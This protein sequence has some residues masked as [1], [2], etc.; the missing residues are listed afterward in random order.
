ATGQFEHQP[1]G[2]AGG[3]TAHRGGAADHDAALAGSGDVDRGVAQARGD[4]E[5]ERGQ[6]LDDRAREGG[7]LAHGAD[8][9]EALQRRDDLVLPA[10]VRV[11]DLDI[12]V[13]RNLRPVGRLEGD[14]LIVVEDRAAGAGHGEYPGWPAE[15]SDREGRRT[16]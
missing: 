10:K 15:A 7:A 5:L 14:I 8:D 3:R 1:N 16:L 13:T 12:E 4:K 6:F 11:K 2:D 9:V